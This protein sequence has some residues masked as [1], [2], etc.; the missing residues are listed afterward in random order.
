MR[1]ATSRPPGS[2]WPRMS[3][4][5]R[6]PMSSDQAPFVRLRQQARYALVNQARFWGPET[7]RC[8]GGDGVAALDEDIAVVRLRKVCVAGAHVVRSKVARRSAKRARQSQP[9]CMASRLR[10]RSSSRPPPWRTVFFEVFDA[11]DVAM[12]EAADFEAK[13]VEPSTHGG[14]KCSVLHGAA[15]GA[16][17]KCGQAPRGRTN[18][19]WHASSDDAPVGG[20]HALRDV[21]MGA[22]AAIEGDGQSRPGSDPGGGGRRRAPRHAS[23][24]RWPAALRRCSARQ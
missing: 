17:E 12:L 8:T 18:A 10:L 24:A 22:L 14:E 21:G 16:L 11:L 6:P 3:S 4:V 5:E 20:Q 9:R 2:R 15:L 1:S 7:R 13:A 19:A 23:S